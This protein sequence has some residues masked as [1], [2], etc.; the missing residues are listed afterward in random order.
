[1]KNNCG[2]RVKLWQV[3]PVYIANVSTLMTQNPSQFYHNG[4]EMWINEKK[5]IIIIYF[6]LSLQPYRLYKMALLVK[7][8]QRA[9]DKIF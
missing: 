9:N 3:K 7:I 4:F 6:F 2:M 1:M 5:R 8:I